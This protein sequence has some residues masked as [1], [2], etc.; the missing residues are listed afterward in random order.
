MALL[1]FEKKGSLRSLNL[2]RELVLMV[3]CP[4]SST[5]RSMVSVLELRE[6]TMS[7]VPSFRILFSESSSFCSVPE[8]FA[9]FMGYA[10][11]AMIS[12][13]TADGRKD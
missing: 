7:M 8:V 2:P 13:Y 12:L 5:S 3:G 1:K 11:F 4:L 10:P 6:V 9:P